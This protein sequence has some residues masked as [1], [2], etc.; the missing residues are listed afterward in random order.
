MTPEEQ[1][2]LSA[3]VDLII[4]EK[5]HQRFIELVHEVNSLLDRKQKRMANLTARQVT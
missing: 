2:Q 4:G 3:L 5:D 1:L